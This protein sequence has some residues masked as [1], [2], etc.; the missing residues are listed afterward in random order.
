MKITSVLLFAVMLSITAE[1]FSQEKNLSLKV[2]KGSLKDVFKSLKQK[3]SYTFVYSE[4]HI[5][6]I[7]V[8]GFSAEESSIEDILNT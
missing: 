4:S 5:E 8:E 6:G 2:E 3:T 7:E 1:T